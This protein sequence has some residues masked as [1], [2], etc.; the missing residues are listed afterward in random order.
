MTEHVPRS[1]LPLLM[2]T[3]VFSMISGCSGKRP[4]TPIAGDP[5]YAK[6]VPTSGVGGLAWGPSIGTA[7]VKALSNC[8]RYAAESG[9]ASATC[10]VT[11]ASCR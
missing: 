9:G 5:C 4:Q 6:A 8:R 10:K 1:I 11:A 2:L 3:L 7:S